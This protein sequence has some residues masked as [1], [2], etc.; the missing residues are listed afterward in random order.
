MFLFLCQE[1]KENMNIRLQNFRTIEE[2]NRLALTD[3]VLNES[4]IIHGIQLMDSV[5]G[6]FVKMPSVKG[7]DNKYRD[8]AFPVTKEAR[9]QINNLVLK[10][11]ERICTL[12]KGFE[13]E[14]ISI[15]TFPAEDK[16]KFKGYAS[17]TLQG[18]IAINGI[19]IM[20]GEKGLFVSMPAW[21][22]KD[23]SFQSFC[24]PLNKDMAKDLSYAIILQYQNDVELKKEKNRIKEEK[25]PQ[26]KQDED[27]KEEE[28]EKQ[29]EKKTP[30]KKKQKNR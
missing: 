9:D 13:P 18:A 30:N 6:K 3:V 15:R 27:Q 8:V 7:K 19:K 4:L 25:T 17:V 2:G 12:E 10:E 11:Y 23:G 20:E 22:K 5:K 29:P 28:P 16:E 24:A 1:R 21:T 26:R 14:D